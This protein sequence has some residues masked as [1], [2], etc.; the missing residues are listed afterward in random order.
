M[1][2][3]RFKW[4]VISSGLFVMYAIPKAN[5]MIA[6]PDKYSE[7]QRYDF[8]LRIVDHMRRHARTTTKYYGLENIPKE[9]G[10]IIYSNH[11]GKYDALGILLAM[12]DTPCGVL[13]EKKQAQRFLSKQVCSLLGGVPIDL[14]DMRAKVAAIREVTN[15]VKNG[16]NFLIFPEGGYNDNKNELQDF[17]N[18]CFACSLSSKGLIVPVVVYDSYKSMNSNTFEKVTTQVHFLKPIPY[19]EYGKLKKS[20]IGELV[21]GRIKD[22]LDEINMGKNN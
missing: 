14:E 21:K 2:N 15:Q 12:K 20:E 1:L 3:L 4:V 17:Q 6:N 9:K 8:A 18:G 16:K 7:Q 19:E 22:K 13:W 11:Q 5:R 10:F